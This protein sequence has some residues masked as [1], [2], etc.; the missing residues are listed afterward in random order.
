[1][2]TPLLIIPKFATGF[3]IRRFGKS[4]AKS[5]MIL[6]FLF[7]NSALWAK[8]FTIAVVKKP[9]IP[10]YESALAGFRK[11]LTNNGY[12]GGEN[13]TIDVY[14]LEDKETISLNEVTPRSKSRGI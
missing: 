12:T 14:S 3:G 13:I 8:P 1:M 11:V 10:I 9:Q 2:K 6:F 5:G 7:S 4:I